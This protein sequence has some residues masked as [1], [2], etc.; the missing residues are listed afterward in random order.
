MK[1]RFAI[2]ALLAFCSLGLFSACGLKSNSIQ[3]TSPD[4]EVQLIFNRENPTRFC[5]L[6]KSD[7]VLHRSS[8]GMVLEGNEQLKWATLQK[9]ETASFDETWKPVNGKT[10]EV[11]NQYNQITFHFLSPESLTMQVIFRCYDEGFAYR[12]FIPEQDGKSELTIDAETSEI[13][14]KNDRTLWAYN[15]ERHNVGPVRWSESDD[16]VYRIP[17]VSKCTDNLYV[18]MH[19]AEIIRYAPFNLLKKGDATTIKIEKT[20]DQLPIKTSWRAF[21][22]GEKPGDLVNA[23]LLPNLN[24]PCKIEDPSWIHPGRAVWDWRVWGHTA[25]DGFEYGLNTIS[26]KRFIDFAAENN[27]SYLLIDADWYGPEFDKESDPTSAREGVNIEECMAYA[28]SKG[29]GVI[30]YLN[31][32]GAKKYGLENILKKFA[33]WGA[34]GVKYGFMRGSWEQKVRH[35]RK[36]VE[37]CA[38]YHLTV[39]FHDNPV[40]PS[41]DDRTWPNLVT[42]EFCHSQAD[43]KRSYFP[44]TIVTTTFVNMMAGPIDNCDGWFDFNTSLGRVRVFEEIPGTVAAEVAKLI[45]IYTGMNIM[46]D[47]PEEYL[48]KDDLFD[49]IRKMPAKFDGFKIIDGEIGEYIVVARK[50][51]VDWFVGALTNREGREIEVDL[52]FLQNDQEFDITIYED[53][54]TTHFINER[55]SYNIRKIEGGKI[56]TLKL[57]LAPGG[58]TAVYLKSK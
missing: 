28:K 57:K 21:I 35:T 17:V 30:L 20:K 18:G 45:V 44:E 23:N 11:R 48:K 4:G 39:N 29:V 53:A 27:I 58:G 26:H 19:E 16:V 55:E 52:S 41:G 13:H 49:C 14:F 9:V 46:P 6:F 37:L 12:Y 5:Q 15:G 24:E 1:L 34:S 22:V 8:L 3:L 38:K 7:T 31:D 51:G 36:V 10:Q 47:A 54:K 25:E 43:A 2:V 32:V 33:N 50:A 56:S 42:K 40:P